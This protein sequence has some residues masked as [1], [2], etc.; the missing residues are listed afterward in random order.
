MYTICFV[1]YDLHNEMSNGRG[2]FKVRLTPESHISYF[3]KPQT[4]S[5]SIFDHFNDMCLKRVMLRLESY[6][7]VFMG[8]LV[9]TDRVL[10]K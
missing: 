7:V 2:R 8:H 5:E 6:E 3:V 10:Q 1:F 4:M 9:L